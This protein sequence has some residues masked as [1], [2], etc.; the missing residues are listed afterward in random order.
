MYRLHFMANL[1]PLTY[2]LYAAAA[3]APVVFNATQCQYNVQHYFEKRSKRRCFS[4]AIQVACHNTIFEYVFKSADRRN[5]T[6]LNT[7][8]GLPHRIRFSII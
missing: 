1:L 6:S 7:L 4:L 2:K 5:Q 3:A 8:I